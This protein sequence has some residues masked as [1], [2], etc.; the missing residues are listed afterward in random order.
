M[1]GRLYILLGDSCGMADI[2]T[3][4]QSIPSAVYSRSIFHFTVMVQDITENAEMDGFAGRHISKDESSR[5]RHVRRA[6]WISSPTGGAAVGNSHLASVISCVIFHRAIP[7]Q[8]RLMRC[9]SRIE[10]Y[11]S[12]KVTPRKFWADTS[13]FWELEVQDVASTNNDSTFE[14][15]AFAE[16]QNRVHE[17]HTANTNRSSSISTE[18]PCRFVSDQE[19]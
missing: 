16:E 17:N 9:R 11:F 3:S 15:H 5:N 8:S 14:Y 10:S 6:I 7:T 2:L 1:V 13:S 19:I 4:R 18:G 12:F